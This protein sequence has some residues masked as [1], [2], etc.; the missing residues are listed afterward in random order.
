MTIRIDELRG[1]DPRMPILPGSLLPIAQARSGKR[2]RLTARLEVQVMVEPEVGARPV[3]GQQWP[4]VPVDDVALE[5]EREMRLGACPHDLAIPAEREDIV[6]QHV[7][8]AVMLVIAARG[9]VVDQV[10]LQADA[11][12]SLVV[13]QPPPPAPERLYE[14]TSWSKLWL[15]LVPG[16]MPSV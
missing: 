11:R 6:P 12:R 4:I 8:P 9:R 10:V 13:V 14:S 16:E 1:G 15:T 5:S 3:T 7:L 2:D